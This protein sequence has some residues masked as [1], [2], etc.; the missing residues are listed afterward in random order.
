MN[1]P[2]MSAKVVVFALLA[3]SY[4]KAVSAPSGLIMIQTEVKTITS[5]L[6]AESL[7]KFF[8]QSFIPKA[9]IKNGISLYCQ[10]QTV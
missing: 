5:F 4:L 1:S 7:K 6:W 10:R 3:H 8:V 9:F 2:L